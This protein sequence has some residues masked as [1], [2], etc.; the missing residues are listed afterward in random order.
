[1]PLCCSMPPSLCLCLCFCLHLLIYLS[2]SKHFY[3][4]GRSPRASPLYPTAQTSPHCI[5]PFSAPPSTRL[6][7]RRFYAHPPTP[8]VR[9]PPHARADPT[10]PRLAIYEES[11]TPQPTIARVH[12][13][14]LLSLFQ[15]PH[16]R[17]YLLFHP[18]SSTPKCNPPARI[19][20]T[21]MYA[22]PTALP[23]CSSSSSSSS[24]A[25]ACRYCY[26]YC[27]CRCR[28]RC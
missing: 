23:L 13:H 6:P 2:P 14:I 25:I 26:C 28:C 10:A 17:I 21:R 11:A 3:Y 24:V 5:H 16:A 1:M 22:S 15:P 19:S 4:S 27:Y 9:L 7:G 8:Y 18:C 20:S 12:V